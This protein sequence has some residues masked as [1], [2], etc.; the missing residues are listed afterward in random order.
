MSFLDVI[1]HDEIRVFSYYLLPFIL[2]QCS[3]RCKNL[4]NG[5][6]IYLLTL[7]FRIFKEEFDNFHGANPELN[8]YENN[9]ENC[10]ILSCW[11]RIDLI[12]YMNTLIADVFA[13]NKYSDRLLFLQR[14]SN[15]PVEKTFGNTRSYMNNSVD[16]VLFKNVLVHEVLRKEMNET[17]ELS[18]SQKSP[19]EKGGVIISPETG[20]TFVIDGES[21]EEEIKLLRNAAF[22]SGDTIEERDLTN[23][24]ALMLNLA[25]DPNMQDMVPDSESPTAMKQILMRWGIPITS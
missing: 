21:I 23:L 13:I 8:Y 1:S 22:S 12:K 9:V 11:T 24:A 6:R 16:E 14:L 2:W 5:Q 20:E 7:T 17:L 4:S 10:E 25:E 15:Y 3:I 19:N 18:N